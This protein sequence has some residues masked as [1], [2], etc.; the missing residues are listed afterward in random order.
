MAPQVFC[1]LVQL[2]LTFHDSFF[3]FKWIRRIVT[4][5]RNSEN[6]I[7]S[8]SH[9][10]SVHNEYTQFTQLSSTLP[11]RW[12][13][14]SGL[15]LKVGGLNSGRGRVHLTLIQV[16]YD[17]KSADNVLNPHLEPQST[18]PVSKLLFQ[19]QTI[20]EVN[21]LLFQPQLTSPV[22]RFLFQP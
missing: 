17:L 21:R 19:P 13:T 20:S 16:L 11:A 14:C 5:H 22:S 9:F 1:T 8:H 2:Q 10:E 6:Y 4:S 7:A 12:D 3:N 18:S 15:D